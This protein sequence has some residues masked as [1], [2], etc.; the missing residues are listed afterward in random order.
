MASS[1]QARVTY[2]LNDVAVVADKEKGSTVLK[3]DLH[4]DQAVCVA[5]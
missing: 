4:A 3:I 1:L 5:R 2:V